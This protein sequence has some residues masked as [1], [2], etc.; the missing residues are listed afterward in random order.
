MHNSSLPAWQPPEGEASEN[1]EWG[2]IDRVKKLTGLGYS[3][4]YEI[5]AEDPDSGIKTFV[6]TRPGAKR[7]ARLF[8]L[9]SIR[10]FMRRRYAEATGKELQS[11]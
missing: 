5:L 6:L 1:E 2:K 10:K 3:R 7:G 8:E 4:I 11:A 9:N